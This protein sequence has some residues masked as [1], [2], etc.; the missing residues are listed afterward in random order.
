MKVYLVIEFCWRYD[1]GDTVGVFS[2][3]A[4]AKYAAYLLKVRHPDFTYKVE[5]WEIDKPC[6][7]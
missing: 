5:E 1:D 7:L 3:E 4:K 6:F 2:T